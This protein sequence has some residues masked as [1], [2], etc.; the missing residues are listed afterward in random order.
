MFAEKFN[1][2][3]DDILQLFHSESTFEYI[4]T[5]QTM[6][7]QDALTL[8]DREVKT[9][10]FQENTLTIDSNIDEGFNLFFVTYEGDLELRNNPNNQTSRFK[11]SYMIEGRI[12][13]EQQ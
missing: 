10:Y 3:F 6:P 9:I 13:F 11:I 2:R 5:Q 8:M 1:C 4:N 7:T 12:N